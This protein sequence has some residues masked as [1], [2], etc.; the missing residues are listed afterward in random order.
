MR[1]AP[2]ARGGAD[3]PLRHGAEPS[4][5][6]YSSPAVAF[7]L[8]R[9]ASAGLYTKPAS[10]LCLRDAGRRK[11]HA[12]FAHSG[13]REFFVA[14]SRVLPSAGSQREGPPGRPPRGG[15][16]GLESQAESGSRANRPP[17]PWPIFPWRRA[18]PSPSLR[19]FVHFL[20]GEG[21]F[22]PSRKLY[23]IMNENLLISPRY[24][25]KN[26]SN[27]IEQK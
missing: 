10:G 17:A 6:S 24:K 8:M 25:I 16:P 2:Q 23:S 20:R 12:A 7:P 13:G 19:Q 27:R 26:K 5:D 22:R 9:T 18:H 3:F 1:P 4:G 11:G 15:S 21:F 14:S